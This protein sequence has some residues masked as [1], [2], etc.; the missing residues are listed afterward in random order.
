MPVNQLKRNVIG[1][2]V[3]PYV[4]LIHVKLMLIKW[5]NVGIFI[6]GIISKFIYVNITNNSVLKLTLMHLHQQIVI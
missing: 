4:K 2:Q 6:H 5:E 1:I 3:L